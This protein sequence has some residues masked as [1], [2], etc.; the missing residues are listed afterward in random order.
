MAELSMREQAELE[1]ASMPKIEYDPA[2]TE[3]FKTKKRDCFGEEVDVIFRKGK[4]GMTIEEVNAARAEGKNVM[5]HSICPA[6]NPRTY[7]ATTVPPHIICEQDVVC[8]LRDGTKIYADIYRPA[9]TTEPVPLIIS[10]GTFGKRPNE[11]QDS[12]KLMG[13]PPATVSTMAKFEAADPAYWCR[14]GYAVAN[15]DPRGVGNSEGDIQSWGFEDANDGYDFVEWAA[16]QSWCSGRVTFFGNS[17]VAMV[18]WRIAATCPPHL[19]CIAVW[20]ATGD[21]YR[22]SITNGGI[23]RTCFE[24]MM[25]NSIACKGWIEDMVSMLKTHPYFDN[26]WLTKVPQYSKIKVPAYICAGLCHFHLR[27][28]LDGWRKIRSPKKWLRVH[29]EMEW[30]DTYANENLE[31]L[32]KFYDRYLKDERNGWEMTPRVRMDV[33]DAYGFDASVRRPEDSFPIKR[34]EYKKLYLDAANQSLSYEPVAEVSEVEYDGKT[35]SC[36]FGIKFNED[37]EIIGYSKLHLFIEC[38]GHNNMDMFPWIK[39]YKADGTYVPVSCMGEDY[40][41][42]WGYFAGNRRELDEKLS[43]DY[44]PVQAHLKDE[45]MEQGEIYEVEIEMFPHSRLWHK[46]EELRLEITGEF[47]KTDWYEDGHLDFETDNG[48]GKHVIHTGGKYASYLQIPVIPPKYV[49]GNFVVR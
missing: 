22:E 34:T 44:N 28:S 6:L 35:G 23:T 47:V 36:S 8:T 24:E 5:E 4:P 13:V 25:L 33:M 43:T 38:R 1:R 45:P 12:W 15:V 14:H 27:G 21:M 30:P 3:H 11:G 10:W 37:T 29:R 2:D 17:G 31:D 9:D 40:R 42:A 19:A 46:G 39:K 18:I 49:S 20:E 32:R 16:Q 7:I 26:Y 41:G 48:N